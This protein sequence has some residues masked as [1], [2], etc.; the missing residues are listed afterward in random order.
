MTASHADARVANPSRLIWRKSDDSGAA[1]VDFKPRA[2]A[3]NLSVIDAS[4][5]NGWSVELDAV[6]KVSIL[7][8]IAAVGGA[9]PRFAGGRMK[10]QRG[11]IMSGYSCRNWPLKPRRSLEVTPDGAR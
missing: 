3:I 5:V 8:L 7:L 6:T 1:I 11:L 10:K 4:E 2:N 9:E